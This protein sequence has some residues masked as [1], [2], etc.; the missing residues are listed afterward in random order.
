MEKSKR[1]KWWKWTSN[2]L[3]IAILLI[4]IIPSWRLQFQSWFQSFFLDEI[5]LTHTNLGTF[6]QNQRNWEIFSMEGE[7]INFNEFSGHPVV[8]NFWA[9]WCASCL[10]ELPQI[11]R[12]KENV[13]KEV[14]FISISEEN[15]D[16]INETSLPKKYD[17]LYCSQITPPFFKVTAYPTLAILDKNWNLVYRS[18]GAAKLDNQKN[19]DFLNG[20]LEN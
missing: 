14:K 16:L 7:L 19:I 18:V 12:L 11:N 5:E 3:F 8:L 13:N 2:L 17:F 6:P 10:A 20:L 9:T 15:I 4:L 1:K